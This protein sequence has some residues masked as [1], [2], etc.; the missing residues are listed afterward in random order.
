[1]IVIITYVVALGGFTHVIAGSVDVF[2]LVETRQA[3]WADFL[4][5]FFIPVLLGNTVGGVALVSVLNYGQV[6]EEIE[7]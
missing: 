1:V 6:A 7:Q 5:R 4:V 2:Y 3:T